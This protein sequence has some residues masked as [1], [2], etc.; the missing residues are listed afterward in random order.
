MQS[1][2]LYLEARKRRVAQADSELVN[3]IKRIVQL[4]AQQVPAG[5]ED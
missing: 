2:G 1:S 5:V 4:R 3:A